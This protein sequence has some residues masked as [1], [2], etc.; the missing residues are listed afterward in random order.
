VGSTSADC[1]PNLSIRSSVGNLSFKF[2]CIFRRCH[3]V[4]LPHTFTAFFNQPIVPRS[5]VV[6]KLAWIAQAG[7]FLQA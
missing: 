4:E 2:L 1:I 6:R 7:L 5:A 3:C